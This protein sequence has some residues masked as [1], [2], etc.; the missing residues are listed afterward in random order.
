MGG[1]LQSTDSIIALTLTAGILFAGTI[2]YYQTQKSTKSAKLIVEKN[3]KLPK[4]PASSTTKYTASSPNKS[5][6]PSNGIETKSSFEMKGYK[7][8]SDGRKTTYF[9]REITEEE[10]VLLGDSTP[11]P[12]L[13]S[14]SSFTDKIEGSIKPAVASST[15]SAWNTA[16]TWEER[17]VTAWAIKHVKELLKLPRVSILVESKEVGTVSISERKKYKAN[18]CCL[19][20]WSRVKSHL[21]TL[22]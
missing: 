21:F 7:M 20:Q 8:T 17:N 16:G 3:D 6:Q 4:T 2:F 19:F 13:S 9:N 14:T 5:V 10:K 18:K 1:H 12:L 11:K 15:G 22:L